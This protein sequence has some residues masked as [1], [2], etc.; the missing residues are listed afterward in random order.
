MV[1]TL[2]GAAPVASQAAAP[3]FCPAGVQGAPARWDYDTYGLRVAS[4]VALPLPEAGPRGGAPD[5]TVRLVSTGPASGWPQPG[6][7][8]VFEQ[9]C[10][11]P[12]HGGRPFVRVYRGP[13]GDWIWNEHA[14]L[15]HVLPDGRRVDVYRLPDADGG[16]LALQILGPVSGRV[17]YRLGFP[18]LHGAAVVAAGEAFAFIGPA[19]QGKTTLA[20][21]FLHRGAALLSDDILPLRATP[22]GVDAAPGAPLMKL[23][24]PTVKGALDLTADLPVLAAHLTKKRLTLGGRDSAYPLATAP[25]R[26]RALYVP[27]RFDPVSAGNAD[28]TITRLAG[29]EAIAL[30]MSQT[31]RIELLRPEEQAAL[32]PI[33]ARLSAQS[34]VRLLR[35]P[36]GF[37]HQDAV[38]ARVLA[39]ARGPR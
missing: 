29:H 18:P 17:L 12:I 9:R 35:Y 28:I 15:C 32:L 26:L 16:A 19:G 2:P 24:E 20:A 30:L 8:L 6:G 38:C 37:E 36:N 39:D 1:V 33:Y 11:C 10:E 27:Q 22:G 13:D 4:E 3:G 5:W 21:A 25:A 31:Y 7:A 14:G 23:W 34:P